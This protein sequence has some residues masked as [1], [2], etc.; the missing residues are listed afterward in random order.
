MGGSSLGLTGVSGDWLGSLSEVSTAVAF[1]GHRLEVAT[2]ASE[3]SSLLR[4]D[5]RE[6]RFPVCTVPSKLVDKRGQ[7]AFDP[8]LF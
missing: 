2:V 5:K 4:I 7:H 3:Y 8:R 1:G 6:L